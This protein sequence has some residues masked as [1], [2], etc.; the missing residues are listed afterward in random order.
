MEGERKGEKCPCVVASLLPPIGDLGHNPGTC[1]Y[2]ELN[3]G[4]L[5]LQA[6]TESTE[7]HQP[8]LI[9][10]TFINLPSLLASSADC[11][12]RPSAAPTLL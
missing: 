5:D 6:S 2:W 9:C 8:G 3:Q 11:V 7:R 4:P 1:P 12:N 10:I